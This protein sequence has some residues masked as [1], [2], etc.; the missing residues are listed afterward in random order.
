MDTFTLTSESN[1]KFDFPEDKLNDIVSKIQVTYIPE[2]KNYI[3][4]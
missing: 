4:I 3:S 1:K 2:T